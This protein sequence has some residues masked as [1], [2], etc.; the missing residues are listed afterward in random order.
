[1]KTKVRTQTYKNGN[2]HYE[3]MTIQILTPRYKGARYLEPMG[4]ITFQK[5]I[6]DPEGFRWYGM[7]FSVQTDKVEY[8]KKMTALAEY[9][10]KNKSGYDAQPEEILQLIGAEEH[11]FFDSEFIPVSDKGKKLFK[12]IKT[13]NLYD[14]IT[15]VNEIVAQ[16]ILD[17]KKIAGAVLEFDKVIDF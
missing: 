12:V 5:T 2:G 7:N 9:I 13:G 15:A 16:K 10:Q 4:E 1:M 14:K 6:G 11:V 3:H 17:K 8:M